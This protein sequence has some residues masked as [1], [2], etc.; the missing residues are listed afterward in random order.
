LIYEWVFEAGIAACFDEIDHAGL[1]GR[2]RGRVCD[3]RVLGWVAA[4][5]RAGIFSEEV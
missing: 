3:K 2:V 4:F 5:L 1:M